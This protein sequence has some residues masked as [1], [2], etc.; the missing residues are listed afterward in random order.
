MRIRASVFIAASLDGFIARRDGGIDWLGEGEQNEDFG[1]RE[2]FDSIDVLAMGRNTFE[3]VLSFPEWPYGEKKVVV[4][5]SRPFTI[6]P[7]REQTVSSSF[8]TPAAL[9]RRLGD[10]GV[11]RVYV[12]GGVT[13][14]RFLSTDAI[15][16]LTITRIPILLGEGIPL[17]GASGRDI[18]LRHVRTR[19][20]PNGYVQSTYEVERAVTA[21]EP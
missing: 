8:E 19:A 4:L 15:D 18:V 16:D 11:K 9:L 2:F 10:D 13:I 14:Q 20:F 1:Y 21:P 3:K 5:T 12:D 17:F 6:P 7:G